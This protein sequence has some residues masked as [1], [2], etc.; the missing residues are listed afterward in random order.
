[1]IKFLNKLQNILDLTL[2][3]DFLGPLA[4]RLYLAPIMWMAG[5]RKLA[6]FGSTAAWFAN[7]DW[8]LGMPIFV[9][10]G[11]YTN[12]NKSSY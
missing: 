9:G 7:A 11:H 4:V 10:G 3:A 12:P 8:G 1:M 5:T 6:N 2:H